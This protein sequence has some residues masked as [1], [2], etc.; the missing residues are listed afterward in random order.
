[1][2]LSLF[3]TLGSPSS[4]CSPLSEEMIGPRVPKEC[5]HQ[6]QSPHW[7]LAGTKMRFHEGRGAH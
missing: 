3:P 4:F 7:T 1:M 2:E 5:V 6:K